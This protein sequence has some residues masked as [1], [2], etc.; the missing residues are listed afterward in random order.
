MGAPS[1]CR[2]LAIASGHHSLSEL[3]QVGNMPSGLRDRLLRAFAEETCDRMSKTKLHRRMLVQV[4]GAFAAGAGLKVLSSGAARA[5]P[6]EAVP[7]SA[8]TARP[9]FAAPANACD[10]HMHHYGTRYPAIP[11]ALR[12]HPDATVADY[13]LL[14]KRIGTMRVVVVTPSLY[15]TD[16]SAT[17]DAMAE[18][19]PSARGVAV[20][21][22]V[23]AGGDRDRLR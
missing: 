20:V 21:T 5:Q 3:R 4:I 9:R 12:P 10:C 15:G 1:G 23:V 18:F 2:A 11:G 8:G 16:N 14:Q 17:L 22:I 13:R 6:L 19:G 7:Y